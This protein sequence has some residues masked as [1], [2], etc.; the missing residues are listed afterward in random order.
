MIF[1]PQLRLGF[2]WMQAKC[3]SLP[4]LSKCS[5]IVT[6]HIDLLGQ[7]LNETATEQ[8]PLTP[9]DRSGELVGEWKYADQVMFTASLETIEGVSSDPQLVLYPANFLFFLWNAPALIT[10]DPTDDDPYRYLITDRLTY[11]CRAA[12]GGVLGTHLSFSSSSSS[13]SSSSKRTRSLAADGDL[14]QMVLPFA[15]GPNLI[16]TKEAGDEPNPEPEPETEGGTEPESESDSASA[17]ASGS[18]S[19]SQSGSGTQVNTFSFSSSTS[20]V[21]DVV[22]AT[23]LAVMVM[24]MFV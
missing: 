3:C 21:G 17:S 1:I 23:G 14:D 15:L 20:V 16:I 11:D 7:V 5:G 10:L 22:V 4:L 18:E 9:G 24:V 19:E 12:M 13:S 6:A 8:W 2:Q